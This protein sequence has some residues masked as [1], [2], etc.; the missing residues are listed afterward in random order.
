MNAEA[1]TAAGY[2]ALREK[3]RLIEAAD[4]DERASVTYFGA[5]M[6]MKAERDAYRNA[7]AGHSDR[8]EAA[9]A[10][11][12][13]KSVASKQIIGHISRDLC[14]DISEPD[15]AGIRTEYVFG[16]IFKNPQPDSIP[17]YADH[18]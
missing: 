5:Y 16:R 9:E 10:A 17:V 8:W 4:P 1:L 11:L 2:F 12:A 18:S 6:E 15:T 14:K 13:E 7:V 3:V